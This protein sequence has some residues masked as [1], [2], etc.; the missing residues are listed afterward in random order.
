MTVLRSLSG[1]FLLSA[2]TAITV[3]VLNLSL[4]LAPIL[5]GRVIDYLN[6]GSWSAAGQ[7]LALLG[8]ALGASASLSAGQWLLCQKLARDL[9]RKLRLL[10]F[11]KYQ[12]LP[13]TY[14][15]RVTTGE[16]SNRILRDTGTIAASL[17]YVILPILGAIVSVS[18]A[19]LGMALLNK[20]LTW[21]FLVLTA[22]WFAS[23]IIIGKCQLS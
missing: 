9:Q 13:I 3:V 22:C 11:E 14:F 7:N 10:L 6:N 21:I 4:I 17:I 19:M 12:R 18:L 16:I 15:T 20:T 1:H 2:L 23:T 5:V 8:I